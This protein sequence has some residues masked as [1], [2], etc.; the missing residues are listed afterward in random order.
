[1][2]VD[3]RIVKK[4][5]FNPENRQMRSGWQIL[6]FF[7]LMQLCSLALYIP[8]TGIALVFGKNPADLFQT[9]NL[10]VEALQRSVS[11]V[12][13]L[14][15]SWFCVSRLS[16]RSFFSI[17]CGFHTGWWR[18]FSI[19]I[20]AA[21]AMVSFIA[22]I[23]WIGGGTTFTWQPPPFKQAL[24]SLSFLAFIIFIA[25]ALEEVM[26]R[27]LPLQVLARNT[28]FVIAMLVISMLFGFIHLGNPNRTVYSTMDTIFAGIWL[29]LAYFKTR[30]LWLPTGL[31]VGWNFFLGSFYGLPVSGIDWFSKNSLLFAVDTGPS[32]FTGGAYGP[33][34]GISSTIALVL[35]ILWLHKTGWLK[36][37]PEMARHFSK[38]FQKEPEQL[39][40]ESDS[41][42]AKG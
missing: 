1:M 41:Q 38:S 5:F 2:R 36:V 13:A 15:A 37:S 32:W 17:G 6:L 33:E 20:I 26:F 10:S 16:D 21:F 23:Q 19:G 7:L 30:S 8:V 4:V 22:S 11:L 14:L 40:S 27:G 12:A 25:A 24:T 42:L 9:R 29:S 31:H 18:D 35:G 3:P 28:N 34:G 39:D